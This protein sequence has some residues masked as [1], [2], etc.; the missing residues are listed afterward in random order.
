LSLRSTTRLSFVYS[1]TKPRGNAPQQK[2]TGPATPRRRPYENDFYR[3]SRHTAIN[4]Y[5]A[6]CTQPYENGLLPL[7]SRRSRRGEP[8][9]P[10]QCG[11]GRWVYDYFLR[12][13]WWQAR[14]VHS[15]QQSTIFAKEFVNPARSTSRMLVVAASPKSQ[16]STDDP[17]RQDQQ[18]V[19]AV[20]RVLVAATNGSFPSAYPLLSRRYL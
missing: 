16:A 12:N 9:L 18:H 17:D 13:A 7:L 11:G 20:C 5:C 10:L 2:P 8:A 19:Q 14:Q 15:G 4:T 1:F 6:G 3:R